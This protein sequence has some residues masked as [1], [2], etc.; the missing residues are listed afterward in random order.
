MTIHK[1]CYANSACSV[2]EPVEVFADN[3]LIALYHAAQLYTLW[4][5]QLP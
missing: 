4:H 3:E 1:N 2:K 5:F